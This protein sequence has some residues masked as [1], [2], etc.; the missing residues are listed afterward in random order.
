[1]KIKSLNHICLAVLDWRLFTRSQARFTTIWITPNR[2]AMCQYLRMRIDAHQMCIRC[3]S[4]VHRQY[5]HIAIHSTYTVIQYLTQCCTC[6]CKLPLGKYPFI[7]GRLVFDKRS[8]F[9]VC[10]INCDPGLAA[11]PT[12]PMLPISL[13]FKS[14]SLPPIPNSGQ[15]QGPTNRD[16]EELV[17]P[18]SWSRMCRSAQR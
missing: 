17:A 7:L 11:F 15:N 6:K 10:I 13:K 1:M 2:M 12:F 9:P 3:A 18:Y 16:R 5:W 8:L 14:N 4:D